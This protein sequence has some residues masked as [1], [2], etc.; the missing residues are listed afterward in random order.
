MAMELEGTIFKKF[1]T[2]KVKDSFQK[3][4]FVI[5]VSDGAYPQRIKM[6]LT[7]D[8]CQLLDSYNEGDKIKVAF[9]IRGSEWQ[10]KYFVNLQAWKI[11]GAQGGSSSSNGGGSY[12]PPP[13]T[14]PTDGSDDGLPF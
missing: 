11:E 4:E 2:Q 1:D 7:Q 5:E 10:G 3:R 14:D 13:P 6:E 8:K 12:T 9:N